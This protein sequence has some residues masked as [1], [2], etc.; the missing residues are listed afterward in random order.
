MSVIFTATWALPFGVSSS[1]LPATRSS[2]DEVVLA[3][4]HVGDGDVE[5]LAVVVAVDE[6]AI[7]HLTPVGDLRRDKSFLSL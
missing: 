7:D 5:R 6:Y 2:S 1:Y 4:R 3:R